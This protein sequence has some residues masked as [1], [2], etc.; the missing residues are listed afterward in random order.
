[1]GCLGFSVFRDVGF[2]TDLAEVWDDFLL[3]SG[4]F[5]ALPPSECEFP[6]MT[7]SGSAVHRGG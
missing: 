3:L 2:V 5:M 6:G 4:F 1:V 7:E